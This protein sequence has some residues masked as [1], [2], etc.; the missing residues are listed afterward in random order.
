MGLKRTCEFQNDLGEYYKLSIYD[1]SFS[2]SPSAFIT[3]GRGFD[4]KYE[5]EDRNRFSGLIPSSVQFDIVQQFS[6]DQ[7]LI[8]DIREGAYKKFQLTIERSTDGTSYDLWWVGNIL[9]DVS[10]E[11]NRPL[12]AQ[13]S[14]AE[15]FTTVT[16]VDGLA[17]LVDLRLDAITTTVPTALTSFMQWTFYILN[18]IIQTNDL[19]GASDIFM[20][21]MVNWANSTL[22]VAQGQD[23][24]RQS[25]VKKEAFEVVEN[26]EVVFISC[27]DVLDRMVRTFG[28]NMYLSNGRWNII[29][30][31]AYS[32]M[33]S[34][35]F[36]RNYLK[37]VTPSVNSS[38]T[39]DFRVASG[40]NVLAGAT[41]DSLPA[42]QEVKV[43][44]NH[45]QSYNLLNEDF[46]IWNTFKNN[47]ITGTPST[48]AADFTDPTGNAGVRKSISLGTITE[49]SASTVEYNLFFRNAFAETST[50]AE[51]TQRSTQYSADFP[52]IATGYNS[53]V[54]K[55]RIMVRLKLVTSGGT[56]Y[57]K[58][59]TASSF[60]ELGAWG[61]A[62]SW[63]GYKYI[64]SAVVGGLI[65]NDGDISHS[66]AHPY[67][68]LTGFTSL[69]NATNSQGG[70]STGELFI[71]GAGAMV[72]SNNTGWTSALA[73]DY[74]NPTDDT[75][76]YPTLNSESFLIGTRNPTL[77]GGEEFVKYLINGENPIKQIFLTVQ[78]TN[79]SSIIKEYP[80]TF[81]GTGPTGM[82]NTRIR[83]T[84]GAVTDNGNNATWQTYEQTSGDGIT[85]AITKILS[86]EILKGRKTAPM[87]MNGALKIS[88]F[89]YL[90]SYTYNGAL[91]VPQTIKYNAQTGVWDGQWIECNTSVDLTALASSS[92]TIDPASVLN[93]NVG[94]TSSGFNNTTL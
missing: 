36:S 30:A 64:N 81:L 38:A 45:L 26:E 41:F 59:L 11:Q 21:T 12:T 19:W 69:P 23:P 32:E 1:S 94:F 3:T 70:W 86:K 72:H 35:Q 13:S 62:D 78:S 50:L 47:G 93:S 39:S 89:N 5:T 44:Y 61:T 80:E 24:F 83:V 91:L 2:G 49:E 51:R 73:F 66:L 60:D 25:A 68:A 10:A 6:A 22:T 31:N 77:S 33:S 16:A 71:E 85:G 17:E 54:V 14:A 4:L 9:S 37:G 18:E 8:N 67:K 79:V 90:N 42:I 15:K 28:A 87:I 7:T 75:N 82:S 55:C 52:T 63:T 84:Q 56:T 27:F 20:T 48:Y 46:V 92:L 88:G 74:I 53:A 58:M 43:P 40:G 76:T 34:G 65:N 29:Q 57:Y